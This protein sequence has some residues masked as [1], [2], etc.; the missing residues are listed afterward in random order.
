VIAHTP[1]PER[2]LRQYVETYIFEHE[3]KERRACSYR[4][5]VSRLDLFAEK[6]VK[7]TE[8]NDDLISRWI[9]AV[10][11]FGDFSAATL[12]D[13]RCRVMQLW[14][15]AHEAG[16]APASGQTVKTWIA[17][18]TGAIT[19]RALSKRHPQIVKASARKNLITVINRFEKFLDRPAETTD[20]TADNWNRFRAWLR[21]TY[22]KSKTREDSVWALRALWAFAHSKGLVPDVPTKDS[23][24]RRAEYRALDDAP[25]SSGPP[26][27]LHRLFLDVYQPLLLRG[28]A[29]T[30]ALQYRINL[31]GC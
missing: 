21:R 22:D 13:W 14:C 1:K 25:A 20:L 9:E 8:L 27:N 17:P 16:L 26:E 28:K 2:T 12:R 24:G 7:L 5:A 31:A 29:A 3:L 4:A 6:P 11:T 15:A 30:T 23:A 18:P 10:T 19:L